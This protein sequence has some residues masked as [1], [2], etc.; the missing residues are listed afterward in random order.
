MKIEIHPKVHPVPKAV[1]EDTIIIGPMI[2]ETLPAAN[3][4]P[5]LIANKNELQMSLRM[6]DLFFYFTKFLAC[7]IQEFSR[8]S[9]ESKSLRQGIYHEN[10]NINYKN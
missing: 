9:S 5:I 3:I 4:I 6:I 8:K 2:L 7:A 10:K 1:Y